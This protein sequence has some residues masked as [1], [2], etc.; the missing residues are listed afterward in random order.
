MHTALPYFP[1][2]PSSA[3]QCS[4][5][6]CPSLWEG[7]DQNQSSSFHDQHGYS[8]DS[9]LRSAAQVALSYVSVAREQFNNYVCQAYRQVC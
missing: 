9:L 5:Q 4:C 6:Q 8:Q 7:L 2:A 1:E 3:A